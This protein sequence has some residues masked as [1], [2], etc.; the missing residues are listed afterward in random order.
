MAK[1]T[2]KGSALL[3]PVPPVLITCGSGEKTNVFTVAWTGIINSQ[4][5]KTYIS[6]RPERWSYNLINET[7]EF[8]IN[9]T[10]S[11]LIRA[12]DFCG[13]RSGRDID[14]FSACSLAT[15]EASEIAC[16]ILSASPLS[17]E[18][19]VTETI[20]MGSH[21]MFMADIVATRVN[22]ELIDIN[23]KLHLEGCSLAAYAH[24]DYFALGKKI[25]Y[26]GFSQKKKRKRL[27]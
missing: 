3:A 12:V 22:E 20:A 19:R 25:G 23:G 5:P 7:K 16:P 10:T 17:I 1:I 24:G 21:T 26:F 2:W 15:E 13:V 27:K 8:A 11:S 4:P 9:L 18:C 6:V 14:K